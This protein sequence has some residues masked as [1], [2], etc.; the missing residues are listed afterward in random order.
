VDCRE[1]RS[2]AIAS[3]RIPARQPQNL[4][5]L[6]FIHRPR[7]GDLD[8]GRCSRP[9]SARLLDRSAESHRLTDL[10]ACAIDETLALTRLPA[11]GTTKLDGIDDAAVASGSMPRTQTDRVFPS[12]AVHLRAL[13]AGRGSILLVRKPLHERANAR[14]QLVVANVLNAGLVQSRLASQLTEII[15][16]R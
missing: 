11:T 7:S 5:V 3:W 16:R 15:V 10:S 12:P 4:P 8:S 9:H 13:R 1:P 2:T 14:T 6:H